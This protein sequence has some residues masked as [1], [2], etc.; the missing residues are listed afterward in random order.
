MRVIRFLAVV[1]LAFSVSATEVFRDDFDGPGLDLT[2]WMIVDGAYGIS[3]GGGLLTMAGAPDHK[4]INTLMTFA[5]AGGYVEA[6][7]RVFLDGDYQKFGFQVNASEYPGPTV[8]FYFD[9]YDSAPNTIS[10][11]VLPVAPAPGVFQREELALPWGQWYELA[12][13]WTPTSVAFLIDGIVRAQFAYAWTDPLPVG[14]WNDRYPAIY[15]DWVSVDA[16][17]G[18][19]P[20]SIRTPTVVIDGCDSGIANVVGPDGCSLADAIAACADAAKNHG[21][22][23]SCVAH[24]TKEPAIRRCAARAD[25]P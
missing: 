12:V 24:V 14:V 17:A 4:R 22:F 23:V 6:K 7:T 9:T 13:R 19:C 8:G 5:P 2:R 1:L 18:A 3:V 16:V 21:D 20:D 10:A 15:A 25:I 11:I